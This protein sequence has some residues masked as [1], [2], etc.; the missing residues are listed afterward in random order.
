MDKRPNFLLIMTD[1][2]RGDCLSIEGHPVLLTPNMDSIGGAGVRFTRCYSPCPSCIAAR[3]SLLSGQ[4]PATH[5]MVGYRDGVE[6]AAPP[7][8]PGVLRAAGYQTYL[9]GRSMHQFPPRKR[10]GY[11]E[12][13]VFC[14]TGA[15]DY[16]EW[17]KAVGPPDS[18]GWMGG[19]VCHNDWTAR[20]WHLDDHLH[21]TNWTVSRALRFLERRDPSCPFFLTVS[22][23]A[24]HPPLQPPA[25]YFERYLRTGVPDPTIGD[26]A[27]PPEND[28]VGGGVAP[29]K[30][31]LSGE[32]MRS[33]R[34]GYYGLINHVDDQIRRLLNPVR[35]AWIG[36]T[37]LLY[38]SDHGEMLGDHYLW[39]KSVPYE[40]SARV[41]LLV[42]APQHFGLRK[43]LAA[44]Q[45][46]GLQDIMPTVLEMAGAEIPKTVEG[47][48]L[49]P[50]MRGE[51]V[52]WREY[53]HIE[54]APL[55]HTLT[56]GREKYIWFA[57]DGREQ[58]FDLSADP[59]ECHDLI[60][61][62]S[63][64]ERV[65]YWRDLL[66]QKLKDRP[67]GFSNGQ[68]LIPGRPYR[69]VLERREEA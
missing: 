12:I 49:L 21:F 69:A 7:T 22:F 4:E 63:K 1:Q 3:R 23:I 36:N 29:S 26:W 37:V 50:L 56:D 51:D 38:T 19:G 14:H 65:R 32:A 16:G 34:A 58:F 55:H 62:S 28:G 18:G 61:D 13:E 2:Q 10:Y 5:G 41:P 68:S 46:V 9:V 25:F 15:D 45:P 64:A 31:H 44:E 40:P 57:K 8:L 27:T 53:V 30:V 42:S 54:H 60:E 6:W 59:S 39:R 66:I 11:E 48:S 17:L 67:E 20:P 43:G 24:P 35:N 47:R 33:T 52:P